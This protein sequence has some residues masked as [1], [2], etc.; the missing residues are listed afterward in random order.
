M[1]TST[2]VGAKLSRWTRANIPIPLFHPPRPHPSHPPPRP[3]NASVIISSIP[4]RHL[5]TRAAGPASHKH[6][7]NPG[8][9]RWKRGQAPPGPSPS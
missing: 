3:V 7:T 9:H 6:G 8:R 4:S 1:Q 5:L 2:S